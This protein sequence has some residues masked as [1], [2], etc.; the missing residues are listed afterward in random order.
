M[1]SD[2]TSAVRIPV[3]GIGGIRTGEDALEF[4]TCGAAA[5]QVG[6]A[7]FYDPTAPVRIAKEMARWCAAH[8]IAAVR[9]V[10][11]SLRR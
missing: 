2:L 5:V 9:E 6:T 4:L 3:V 8:G 7:T 1:V 11:G 10:I